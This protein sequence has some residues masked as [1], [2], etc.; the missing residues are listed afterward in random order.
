[1]NPTLGRMIPFKEYSGVQNM[2]L[3]QVLQEAVDAT[4]V[5]V[6]RFYG[7]K[8][9]TLSLGY[10]QSSSDRELHPQSIESPCVRRATGGGALMHDCELTYSL[11]IP[12]SAGKTGPRLDLYEQIHAGLISAMWE[13]GVKLVPFGKTSKEYCAGGCK[14]FLCFQRR[15]EE[16]LILHG[17]KVVGSA[18]RKSRASL[19][20]HGSILLN[21]SEYAPELPGIN[22]I[23]SSTV[24]VS[25]LSRAIANK[26]SSQLSIQWEESDFT[27][28]EMNEST[29]IATARFGSDHWYTRR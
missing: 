27:S 2:S 14:A 15:T 8:T 19:L 16:D 17:Y 10:F 5:P 12:Q 9:A 11:V 29:N 20:Q 24:C 7:W 25:D 6:L 18:Q 3:D 13:F 23:G 1:M 26:L 21:A 28:Q 4:Q 22:D